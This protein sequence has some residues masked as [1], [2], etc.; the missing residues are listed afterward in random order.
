MKQ[1]DEGGPAA[2]YG[3]E[4]EGI[5]HGAYCMRSVRAMLDALQYSP[6]MI[7]NALE[8]QLLGLRL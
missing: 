6:Q 2:S 7:P 8:T 5:A 3:T 4:R 1:Q